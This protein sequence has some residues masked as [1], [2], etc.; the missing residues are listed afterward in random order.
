MFVGGFRLWVA[1]CQKKCGD[2]DDGEYEDN[3]Q[4]VMFY[5]LKSFVHLAFH[6]VVVSKRVNLRYR[7]VPPLVKDQCES[8][9]I[10]HIHVSAPDFAGRSTK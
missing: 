3:R 1:I 10:K 2:R 6:R 8:S 7:D 4:V 9:K 5:E